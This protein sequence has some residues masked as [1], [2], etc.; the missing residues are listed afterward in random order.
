MSEMTQR[1]FPF[2]FI[3]VLGMAAILAERIIS[4]GMS[5]FLAKENPEKALSWRSD[6]PEALVRSAEKALAEKDWQKARETALAAI[7]ANALDGRPLR[8]L[9]LVYAHEGKS[10]KARKMMQDAVILSPR[11]WQSQLWLLEDALRRRRAEDAAKHLDALLRVKPELISTMLPQVMV[12]A[13]NPQAQKALLEQLAL[14]PPWR[15]HLMNALAA[16]DYPVNQIVPFFLNLNEKS[17]LDASEYLPLLNRL[18][19]ENRYDQAYLTWANLIPA[20]QRKYLGNVFDGGF[21]LPIEDHIGDFAW[22][23]REV[24]GAEVQFMSTDGSV[25]E[26]SFYVDFDDRRI[27]YAHL[28]QSLVLPLGQWQISYTAKAAQLDS[29]LGLVWRVT[30]L[31]D[32]RTLAQS[33]PMK[34]QFNW[35][36]MAFSFEVPAGCW[37]QK[38]TLMIP[39]RIPSETQISGSLWLDHLEIQRV[40]PE[41]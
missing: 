22:N 29:P 11:D 3:L 41:L 31:T 36:P 6:H 32:G 20:E 37:G 28:S 2:A 7:S 4:L 16:S 10:I 40:D 19:K 27:P 13:L 24:D 23:V 25:G 33:E 9:A 14:D 15:R 26:S 17:K 18:N 8:V 39:A 34:G 35:K 21:E 5:D 38:L 12:L 1:K 30:C